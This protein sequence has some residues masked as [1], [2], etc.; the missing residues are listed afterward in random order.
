MKLEEKLRPLAS[1]LG[2]DLALQAEV[3]GPGIQKNKYA[4]PAVTLRVFNV[5]NVDSLS[6]S[7]PRGDAGGSRANCSSNRC[8]SL[9]RWC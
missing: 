3:I 8:R 1:G 6:A 9:A 2:F 4:L 7:R 5:L